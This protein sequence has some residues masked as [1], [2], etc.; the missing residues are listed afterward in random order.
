M[1]T[2]LQFHPVH[3]E[4]IKLSRNNTIAK[5]V[6]SFCK[7]IC[8]SNRTVQIREKFY[9]RLLTK[10]VQWTGFLRLG[11]TTCDPNTHRTS[12]SL[13][14]HACPDLTCRPGLINLIKKNNELKF[15]IRRLLGE[16]CTRKLF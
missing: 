2:I 12:S 13:P 16:M 9:V 15:S 3:G 11:V 1:N 8:F 5:R 4:H 10:S 7:G 6:D 14:R